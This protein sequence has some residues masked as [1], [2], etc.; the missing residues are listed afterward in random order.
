MAGHDAFLC[1]YY[2]SKYQSKTPML[3]R[4]VKQ[5]NGR[6]DAVMRFVP[7]FWDGRGLSTVAGCFQAISYQSRIVTYLFFDVETF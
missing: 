3:Q 1:G 4:G 7:V 5:G 6:I 2:L